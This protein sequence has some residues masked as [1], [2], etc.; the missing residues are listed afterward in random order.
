[1]RKLVS[2]ISK[3]ASSILG[4]LFFVISLSGCASVD[5]AGQSTASFSNA[6]FDYD[7]SLD[8]TRFSF[9]MYISNGTTYNSDEQEFTFEFYYDDVSLGTNTLYFSLSIDAS[10]AKTSY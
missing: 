7:S 6:I 4:I 5:S 8:S 1:M 2:K 3:I 9:Y 10:S